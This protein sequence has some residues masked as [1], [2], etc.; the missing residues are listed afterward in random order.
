[1]ISRLT[2]RLK[3]IKSPFGLRKKL[4]ALRTRG[5]NSTVIL[6]L[7]PLYWRD[8]SS[9]FSYRSSDSLETQDYVPPVQTSAEMSRPTSLQTP[10]SVSRSVLTLTKSS[11]SLGELRLLGC[12]NPY[13]GRALKSI[14][15]KTS[16]WQ[17]QI[18]CIPVVKRRVLIEHAC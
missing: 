8:P 15:R 1:M 2:S 5:W 14:S 12:F 16:G 7:K 3:R 4:N 18:A 9:S 10:L 17:V 11:I 6:S 13:K